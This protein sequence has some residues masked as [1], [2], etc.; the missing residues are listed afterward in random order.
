MSAKS[1]NCQKCGIWRRRLQRDHI[2]PRCVKL[3]RRENPNAPSNLQFLCANCHEDKTIEDEKS[4]EYVKVREL[5]FAANKVTR[6]L[7]ISKA[8]QGSRKSEVHRLAIAKSMKG[9]QH[10]VDTKIRMSLAQK[11]KPRLYCRKRVP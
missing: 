5:R 1:G 3:M 9:K 8:L 6:G 10:S 2:V 11:G 7:R 4:P